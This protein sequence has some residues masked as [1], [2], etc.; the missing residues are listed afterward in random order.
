MNKKGCFINNVNHLFLSNIVFSPRNDIV[1]IYEFSVNKKSIYMPIAFF[2]TEKTN[3]TDL[4]TKNIPL[5]I[6]RI[7]R[8]FVTSGFLKQMEESIHGEEGAP[9]KR[10]NLILVFCP[11]EWFFVIVILKNIVETLISKSIHS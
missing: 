6:Q 9:Y 3:N 4:R 1:N 11:V 2:Q 7:E 5:F 10:R 8:Y